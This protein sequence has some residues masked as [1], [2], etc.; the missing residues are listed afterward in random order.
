MEKL[1]TKYETKLKLDHIKNRSWEEEETFVKVGKAVFKV[2]RRPKQERTYRWIIDPPTEKGEAKRSYSVKYTPRL[3]KR[4]KIPEQMYNMKRCF[5]TRRDTRIALSDATFQPEKKFVFI[6]QVYIITNAPELAEK[7][8]RQ[9]EEF[10]LFFES[11]D[12]DYYS[13]EECLELMEQAIIGRIEVYQEMYKQSSN[14]LYLAKAVFLKFLD[15]DRLS[16]LHKMYLVMSEECE[17]P[18]CYVEGILRK[19]YE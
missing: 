13:E 17:F 9:I 12:E 7:D 2:P 19:H 15:F 1:F 10:R 3:G 6:N 4:P 18:M 8:L 5:Q 11:W 14:L 16:N